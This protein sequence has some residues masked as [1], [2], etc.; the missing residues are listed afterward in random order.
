MLNNTVTRQFI[1]CSNA[2]WVF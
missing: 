1:R 2:A